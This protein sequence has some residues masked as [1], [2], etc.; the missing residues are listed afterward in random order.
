MEK[1]AGEDMGTGSLSQTL[2]AP[3]EVSLFPSS[4]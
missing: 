2:P 4:Q 3:T 1:K